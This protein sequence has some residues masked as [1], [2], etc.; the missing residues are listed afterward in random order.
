MINDNDLRTCVGEAY[1]E[2]LG[3]SFCV[4]LARTT[5][6]LIASQRVSA[7]KME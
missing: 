4:D 1:V 7:E 3:S 6:K 2:R 5:F